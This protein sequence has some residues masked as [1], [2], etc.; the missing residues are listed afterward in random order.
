MPFL[1]HIPKVQLAQQVERHHQKF[2]LTLYVYDYYNPYIHI[3]LSYMYTIVT[4]ANGRKI[5]DM[6]KFKYTYEILIQK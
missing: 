1:V 4:E 3:K 5:L 2:L 6:L